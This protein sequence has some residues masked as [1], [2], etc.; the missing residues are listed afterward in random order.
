MET[1]GHIYHYAIQQ[2]FAVN[3]QLLILNITSAL[4]IQHTTYNILYQYVDW[5]FMS[6]NKVKICDLINIIY[7]MLYAICYI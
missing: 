6:H 2:W 7:S 5:N 3:P 4:Y 1:R